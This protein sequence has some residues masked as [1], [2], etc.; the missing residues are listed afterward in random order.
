MVDLHSN[1]IIIGFGFSLFQAE[2]DKHIT[3]VG[4]Q[5]YQPPELYLT[6]RKTWRGDV[7][8]YGL[9]TLEASLVPTYYEIHQESYVRLLSSFLK[10]ATGVKAFER[11]GPPQGTLQLVFEG[12]PIRN[13][14]E[15]S[16]THANAGNNISIQRG[17]PDAD[18]AI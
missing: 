16:G 12:M 4:H 2:A 13:I 17:A 18:A 10:I 7:Y 11:C 1:A 15:A 3:T 6:R 5:K 8:A 14:S 9:L